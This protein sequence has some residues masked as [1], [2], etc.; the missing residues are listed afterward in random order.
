MY[1]QE[2]KRKAI[3]LYIKT[4]QGIKA[5]ISTLGYPSPNMLRNWYRSHLSSEEAQQR[6]K[7][8]YTEEYKQSVIDRYYENGEDIP[9]TAKQNGVPPK[10]CRGW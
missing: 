1:T 5:V 3:E 8:K 9:L 10:S 4:N 7:S 2:E 6:R